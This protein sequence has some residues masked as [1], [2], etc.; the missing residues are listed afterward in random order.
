MDIIRLLVIRLFTRVLPLTFTVIV[1]SFV[2]IQMSPG[3][4]MDIMTSDMQLSEP[5][6][7]AM[8]RK[9]YGMDQPLY[10][11]LGKYLW[12]VAHL[13]FGFS[14]RQNVPVMEAIADHLPAT[15]LLMLSSILLAIIAGVLGGVT[16]AVRA[17][18]I[19]DRALSFLAIGFFA[20][21]AFWAGIMLTVLFSVRLG[22]LPVGGMTSI[23][24]TG[25]VLGDLGDL[26]RHLVLPAT[27]LALFY[28]AMYFRITRTAMLEVAQAD[29]VRT[30][31]A[32]G[33]S[34]RRVRFAHI[35]RNALLP[36]VTMIGLQFGTVLSGSVII[37]TVCNW[38]GIGGL[39]FDGVTTRDYPVVLG[40]LILGSFV[41]V[42]SNTVVDLIYVRLDPRVA[43]D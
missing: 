31:Y 3:S 29:F 7:I 8:L 40:I 42:L 11:Q 21:P 38:P 30:A 5:S 13:D 12:A 33:L 15:L 14:Y 22:W 32:K 4:F 27:S 34:G 36:V 28:A 43:L 6:V 35:L 16:A 10:I 37:E 23:D 25:S 2:L 1:I 17:N 18:S 19:V 9:T 24:G 39:L 41:V 26:V 20:A